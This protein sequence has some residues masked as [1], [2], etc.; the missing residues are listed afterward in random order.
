MLFLELTDTFQK[1]LKTSKERQKKKVKAGKKK[2]KDTSVKNRRRS[3][4]VRSKVN[5][6]NTKSMLVALISISTNVK[7]TKLQISSFIKFP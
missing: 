4:R 7:I 3:K 6:T 1:Q 2:K 5:L